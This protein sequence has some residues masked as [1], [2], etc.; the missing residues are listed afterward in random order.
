MKTIKW[1]QIATCILLAACLLLCVL[2]SFRVETII[3]GK[4]GEKGEKGDVGAQGEKGEKGDTGH[5]TISPQVIKYEHD[6]KYITNIILFN[7]VTQNYCADTG[8][9]KISSVDLQGTQVD[10]WVD[11]NY[12]NQLSV[13]EQDF[14]IVAG[15]INCFNQSNGEF[16]SQ[17]GNAKSLC[18]PIKIE[19]K[20][21]E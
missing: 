16:V 8:I 10:F 18:T 11:F 19:S 17:V 13:T 1:S 2:T 12:W 3:E 15:K 9:L 4:Q 21:A 6:E 7:C 5:Y 14:I 20:G